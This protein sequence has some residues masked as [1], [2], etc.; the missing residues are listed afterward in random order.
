MDL[1]LK[2]K[3][4]LVLASS[5]GLGKSVALELA[6]EGARVVICGRDEA[7]LT[8]TKAEIASETDTD[9]LAVV[10]DLNKQEDRIRLVRVANEKWGDIDILVTNTGGPPSGPFEQFGPDDWKDFFNNLFV[11]AADVIKM[12]LPGMKRK[13]SGSILMI[14]SVAIKQPVDNLIASNAVRSG[15]LGFMKSLANEAGPYGVTVNNLM[16]GFTL[17]ERLEKLIAQNPNMNSI[18]ETIPMKRFGS[19]SEFAAAAAFLVSDQARYITGVSLPVDGG[20][21]KG[22]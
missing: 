18:A 12:V 11:S 5:K 8:R 21:T 22:I 7:V 9:I 20:W 14:T 16:P 4:A 3:T 10:C 19:P 15:L 2:N 17:T 6:R 13:K 1:G